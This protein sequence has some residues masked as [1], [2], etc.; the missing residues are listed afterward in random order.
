MKFGYTVS[1]TGVGTAYNALHQCLPVLEQFPELNS[2]GYCTQAAIFTTT[3]PRQVAINTESTPTLS[4]GNLEIVTQTN[5]PRDIWDDY[6]PAR[7]KI[8]SML[9]RMSSHFVPEYHAKNKHPG[10]KASA[11]GKLL[12]AIY[13]EQDK[14][15]VCQVSL[16]K[17]W[18][19]NYSIQKACRFNRGVFSAIERQLMGER[20]RSYTRGVSF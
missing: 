14:V 15:I 5:Y 7:S 1:F 4:W 19:F 12:D 2:L 18:E 11:R 17:M 8:S 9:G 3:S 13:S 20:S 16:A 10:F 6:P